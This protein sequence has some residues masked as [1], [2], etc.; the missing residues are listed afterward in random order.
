MSEIVTRMTSNT[1]TMRLVFE[2]KTALEVN[3][4]G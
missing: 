1:F 2:D 4:T 3:I